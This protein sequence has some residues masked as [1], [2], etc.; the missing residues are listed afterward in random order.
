MNTYQCKNDIINEHEKKQL[1][2]EAMSYEYV[3]LNI[4][5]T[6]FTNHGKSGTISTYKGDLLIV[7]L[8]KKMINSINP[9]LKFS[10]ANFTKFAPNDYLFIHTD[11][12]H[13]RATCI[14]WALYP[15]LNDF[16]PVKYYNED[17]TL[18][19]VIYYEKNPLI[20][21]T[22]NKHSCKNESTEYRYTFQ[23]C[24]Y[25]PIETL[26]E[27]DQKEELFNCQ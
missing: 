3:K 24:F 23:I 16:S 27:L 21:T 11:D 12:H 26:A 10:I 18:N 6:R 1:I 19:E 14:T 5:G 13:G 20:I 15:S 17:E 22:K 8:V 4:E 7:G 2:S 9:K 25:D